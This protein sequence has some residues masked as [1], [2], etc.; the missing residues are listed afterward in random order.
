MTHL[1]VVPSASVERGVVNKF[2]DFGSAGDSVVVVDRMSRRIH[3]KKEQ[4]L[5]D[6]DAGR[7]EEEIER[8]REKERERPREI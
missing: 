7:R 8:P 5:I 6:S 1:S 2:D 4:R 3:W